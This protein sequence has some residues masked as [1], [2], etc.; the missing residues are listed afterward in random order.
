[1]QVLI[2]TKIIILITLIDVP[3]THFRALVLGDLPL[4]EAYEY[5]LNELKNEKQCRSDFPSELFDTDL[6]SF[7]KI[8]HLT[9]GRMWFISSYIDTVVENRAKITNGMF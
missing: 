2:L 5:Y 6:K 4:E 9:G 3:T 7:N 1:M 8:F